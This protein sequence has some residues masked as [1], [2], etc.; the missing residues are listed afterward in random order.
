MIEGLP[1]SHAMRSTNNSEI[2]QPVTMLLVIAQPCPK[3]ISLAALGATPSA[4]SREAPKAKAIG[5]EASLMTRDMR[6]RYR[7]KRKERRTKATAIPSVNLGNVHPKAVANKLAAPSFS[8]GRLMAVFRCP[9]S[10]GR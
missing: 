7:W 3:S 2:A 5:K 4:A 9:M 8:V 10:G 1:T 6:A